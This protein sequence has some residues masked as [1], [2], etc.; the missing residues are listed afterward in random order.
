M[1]SIQCKRPLNFNPSEYLAN[2]TAQCQALGI[3]PSVF[4]TDS[5]FGNDTGHNRF[6]HNN[7]YNIP[8]LDYLIDRVNFPAND[9]KEKAR[10]KLVRKAGGKIGEVMQKLL[11]RKRGEKDVKQMGIIDGTE[12]SMWYHVDEV[13]TIAREFAKNLHA[14]YDFWA[15]QGTFVPVAK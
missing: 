11:F 14:M 8:D 9:I 1:Q 13:N 2:L 6:L 7:S 5:Y 3:A 4:E 10:E 12:C 15:I